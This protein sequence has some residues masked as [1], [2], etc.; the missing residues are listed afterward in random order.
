MS[1]AAVETAPPLRVVV[2]E[3][4][5][6]LREGL[7][8]L[9]T[10]AGFEVVAAVEDE[11][12]L[13]RR[14]RGNRPDVAIIDVR[15]PPTR[16]DEGLRAATQIREDQPD[17]GLLLVS[18]DVQPRQAVELLSRHPHGIGYLLK[19]RV[20]HSDVLVDAIQRVAAGGSVVDRRVV[21]LLMGERR[22]ADNPIASLTPRQLEVLELMAEGLSNA[23]IAKRLVVT[24]HAVEKQVSRI[25]DD[26][27]LPPSHSVSRRVLAVLMYLDRANPVHGEDT[28]GT[29]RFGTTEG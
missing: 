23:A 13:V 17:I 22:V 1:E 26:L 9:L 7:V 25:F 24:K 5:A 21:S 16:T 27:D 18:Q 29:G 14:V 10:A 8:M 3:D 2:A 15:L 4:E 11:A 6:L 20:S 28:L 12:S 19:Q